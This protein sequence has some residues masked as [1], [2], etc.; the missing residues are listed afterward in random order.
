MRIMMIFLVLMMC[1]R[2]INQASG[3]VS[4][5][6]N[7]TTEPMIDISG[8]TVLGTHF[9]ISVVGDPT[10]TNRD[11]FFLILFSQSN[12][13]NDPD[14]ALMTKITVNDVI[15]CWLVNQSDWKIEYNGD[16]AR[17]R[18]SEVSLSFSDFPEMINTP[19]I[20]LGIAGGQSPAYDFTPD[21]YQGSGFFSFFSTILT[22]I[23]SSV[24]ILPESTDSTSISVS[25]T[26][27]INSSTGATSSRS[28]SKRSPI[29][30]FNLL[31]SEFSLLSLLVVKYKHK[32]RQNNLRI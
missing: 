25:L 15:V 5:A 20:V 26:T 22:R 13:F 17:I 32:G 21:Q 12:N 16:S 6:V 8:Y 9:D 7:D 2:S 1:F 31:I 19:A 23:D 11:L 29:P 30:V 18:E 27:I 3:F 10:T 14:A 24:D 4:D 28:P